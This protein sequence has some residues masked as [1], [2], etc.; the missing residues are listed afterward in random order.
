MRIIANLTKLLTK[1]ALALGAA[2]LLGG[3]ALEAQNTYAPASHLAGGNWVRIKIADEGVHQLT[4]D[5][6]REWGFSDPSKVHVYGAGGTAFVTSDF[7]AVPDDMSPTVQTHTADNRLLFYADG[8]V[9]VKF[10]SESG[11]TTYPQAHYFLTEVHRNWYTT[12]NYYYLS[13]RELPTSAPLP[14]DVAYDY[15]YAFPDILAHPST[16]LIEEEN[17]APSEGS[18]VWHQRPVAIGETVT[19][20]V[21]VR[22]YYNDGILPVG[23][24]E[25]SFAG[26]ESNTFSVPITVSGA[27]V[28]VVNVMNLYSYSGT[29]GINYAHCPFTGRVYFDT[30]EGADKLDDCTLT[31]SVTIPSYYTSTYFALDRAI[32]T[33]PRKNIL[34]EGENQLILDIP[35]GEQGQ[36][37]AVETGNSNVMVWNVTNPAKAFAHKTHYNSVTSSAYFTLDQYYKVGE[38]SGAA[39]F[40]VFRPEEQFA[41]AEFVDKLKN[42]N[43]HGDETPELA[44]ITTDELLPYAQELAEAHRQYDGIK[45]NVYTQKEVFNEFSYGAPNVMAYKRLAK[46]FYDRGSASTTGTK[47]KSLLLYGSTSYD[48][49]NRI[50]GNNDERLLTYEVEPIHGFLDTARHLHNNFATDDYFAKLGD[51]FDIKTFDTHRLVISVGRIPAVNPV[52]A[53]KAN[54]KL[55]GYIANPPSA[56]TYSRA[57]LFSD[58]GDNSA[59]IKQSEDIA[60]ILGMKFPL[61]RIK[62]HNSLTPRNG[63][64]PEC[65]RILLNALREGVG[66]FDYAGH[67]N[68]NSF[69]GENIYTNSVIASTEY[70]IFPVAML[71]TC[72]AYT[73]DLN[74]RNIGEVMFFQENG[75]VIGAVAACR[76]VYLHYNALIEKGMGYAWRDAQV[77]WTLGDLY[78]RAHNYA[79]QSNRVYNVNTL[80]YNLL[81]DPALRVPIA[82]RNARINAVNGVRDAGTTVTVIPRQK[83]TVEGEATDRSGNSLTNFNGTATVSIY[84][85]VHLTNVLIANQLYDVALEQDVEL[86]QTLLAKKVVKVVNGKFTADLVMPVTLRDN[87]NC[88]IV[89]ALE[90]ETTHNVSLAY[91]VNLK[92]DGSQVAETSVT[93]PVI[94]DMYINS[95]DFSDGDAVPQDFTLYANIQLGEA[96]L[97]MANTLGGY[98]KVYLDGG[99]LIEGAQHSIKLSDDNTA[100]LTLPVNGMGDGLH[101]LT[102]MLTDNAGN[103][104]ERMVSFN[105][106][107]NASTATLLVDNEVVRDNVEFGLNHNFETIVSTRLIVTD[108]RGKTVFSAANPAMPYTWDL[109]DNNGKTVADGRYTAFMMVGG[110]TSHASTARVPFVVINRLTAAN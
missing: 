85:G 4:Y 92:V 52:D 2:L 90:D 15:N 36:R 23:H 30:P 14:A 81:G 54:R 75:G 56:E 58:D 53:Q 76:S 6:L 60:N 77:G 57:L 63:S 68:A 83:V 12:D 79:I 8:L 7:K 20:D 42:Q 22:D 28:K 87:D 106:N 35:A 31:F 19:Q 95:P 55:I 99:R 18:Q 11:N 37:V 94:A 91:A 16:Q 100:S 1:G 39:R 96:G 89:A 26:K 110:E 88:R 73:Y 70:T 74:Q 27:D 40:V 24:F 61:T 80:C 13:D 47:F 66:Y 5:Q 48:P 49:L 101:T 10:T 84:D 65:Q 29:C 102:L 98:A 93:P 46:M 44:I 17:I 72:N 3:T 97:G 82:D 43:I 32:L 9:R 109:R 103:A 71:S 62:A 67:G 107:N 108:S 105:V 21:T 69:T 78:M 45:V 41:S 38:T 25:W 86:D 50:N 51:D 33:Y 34:H 104:V 59:H 64:N